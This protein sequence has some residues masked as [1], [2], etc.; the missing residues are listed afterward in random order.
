MSA[1]ADAYD[2]LRSGTLWASTGRCKGFAVAN[3]G[4]A[5][6]IDQYVAALATGDHPA[7]PALTTATGKGIVGMLAALIFAPPPPTFGTALPSAMPEAAGPVHV[8]STVND[9]LAAL[10][11][12][13][14]GSRIQPRGATY[15]AGVTS[16]LLVKTNGTPTAPVCIEA[17]PG[18]KPSFAQM[19][20]TIGGAVRFRGIGFARNSY[21][22][23]PRYGQGGSSP[24]GNVNVYIDS[25]YVELDH[26]DVADATMSG[27]FIGDNGGNHV[28]IWNSDIHGNGTTPDDHGIYWAAGGVGSLVAN[29]RIYDN[30]RF[31]LQIQYATADLIATCC[32]V[33]RNGLKMPAGYPGSGTV[34]VSPAAGLLLV[35]LI[36]ADNG[37]FGFK[38]YTAASANNQLAHSLAHGNP[39]G[40]K[41]GTFDT[42]TSLLT[43]DPLLD[44]NLRPGPGSPAIG[45]GDPAY[46]PPTD[47]DGTA[48]TVATL[49]CYA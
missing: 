4:E 28:R 49:G 33:A 19:V 20:K 48:R 47:I 43:G 8:V 15:G 3:P 32:T 44:A 42:V 16:A 17:Y 38:S 9:L 40:A 22:T 27:I 45:A 1:L 24:G 12:V 14:A 35:N 30:A 7:V 25:N 11:A 21:P 31:G 13:P 26:C 5:A 23:D 18:E 29:N 10:A 36:S 34:Q 39:A 2:V 41:Y 37:E 46:T 6:K